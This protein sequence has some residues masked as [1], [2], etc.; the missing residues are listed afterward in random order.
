MY[1]KYRKELLKLLDLAEHIRTVEKLYVGD[2]TYRI[3]IPAHLCDY[4]QVMPTKIIQ[5]NE[6]IAKDLEIMQLQARLKE[7]KKK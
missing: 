6:Q 5:E 1:E 4:F 3:D 7:L 2:K